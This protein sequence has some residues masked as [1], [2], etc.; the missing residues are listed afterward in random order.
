MNDQQILAYAKDRGFHQHTVERWLGLSEPDRESLLA[1]AQGLKA[2]ENHLRD[3]LDWLQEIALR[4]GARFDEILNREELSR[5]MSD[6]RLGRN[7]K[8]KRLK[9]ELRRLRF[10]RLAR[11]EEDVKR[12]IR[13]MKLRP[14]ILVTVPPGLEGGTMT[15]EVRATS[16]DELKLLV[17]EVEDALEREEMREIFALL[18]GRTIE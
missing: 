4:D 12:R 14:Q 3:F 6:P 15:I 16:H 13:E 17:D 9:D 1:L 2:G 18:Q 10:P 11:I 8:L 5:I 7:D